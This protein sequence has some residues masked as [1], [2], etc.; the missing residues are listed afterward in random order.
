M[1]LARRDGQKQRGCEVSP[2][3]GLQTLLTDNASRYTT[4]LQISRTFRDVQLAYQNRSLANLHLRRP[5]AALADA[6]ESR[7]AYDPVTTEMGLLRE[8]A[9]LYELAKYDQCLDRLQTL[10]TACPGTTSA[11]LMIDRVQARLQEQ[12]T[13]RYDF[14]RMHKQAK[15]TPALVDCATYGMPVE[16]RDSPGQG[17]GLFTTRNVVAGELL[18]CEKAFEYACSGMHQLDSSQISSDAAPKDPAAGMN[19]YAS[20][21]EQTV[22]KLF[23]DFEAAVA[24]VGLCNRQFDAVPS[25]EVDGHPVINS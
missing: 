13:G 11:T 17:R 4:A 2:R 8:A 14:Q 18:I 9:A 10:R 15:A 20:L 23:H 7:G 5:D 12:Q 19:P 6:I 24:F 16:V 1:P 3:I 25:F 22:Q 21:V